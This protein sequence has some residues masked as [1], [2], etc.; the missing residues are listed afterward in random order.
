MSPL[1]SS[2]PSKCSL[3]ELSSKKKKKKKSMVDKRQ[4]IGKGDRENTRRQTPA[5]TLRTIGTDTNTASG[6]AHTT[7]QQLERHTDR[8]HLIKQIYVFIEWPFSELIREQDMSKGLDSQILIGWFVFKNKNKGAEMEKRNG[9]L[10]PLYIG[11]S[12]DSFWRQRTFER[13][14]G[15][16]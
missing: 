15:G 1:F 14:G 13:R 7:T 8:H 6:L 12:V 11:L 4:S 10:M 3:E 9:D 2:C 5:D 16:M